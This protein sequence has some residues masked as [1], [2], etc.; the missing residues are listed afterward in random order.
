V[1]WKWEREGFSEPLYHSAPFRDRLHGSRC[2]FPADDHTY[3]LL[4]LETCAR[5]HQIRTSPVGINETR[6]VYERIWRDSDPNA[7]V[8]D[9]FRRMFFRDIARSDR[10]ARFYNIET[11]LVDLA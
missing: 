6:T 9:N 8:Y 11:E 2:L 5:L 4:V 1:A 10:I 3:R 7:I